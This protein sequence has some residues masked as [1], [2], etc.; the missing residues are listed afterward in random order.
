MAKFYIDSTALKKSPRQIGEINKEL[1]SIEKVL[2]DISL[3]NWPEAEMQSLADSVGEIAKDVKEEA[4]SAQDLSE[5][6][7]KIITTYENSEASLVAKKDTV[8]QN[9]VPG[10]SKEKGASNPLEALKNS[11]SP[12]AWDVL[13]FIA[14]LIPGLNILVDGY[15]LVDDINKFL[16][17]GKISAGEAGVLALDVISLG[18]DIAS[19]GS[20]CK[21]IKGAKTAEK[22]AQS[23][24]KETVRV[25]EKNAL[26]KEA[27]EQ[28]AKSAVEK[29]AEATAKAERAAKAAENVDKSTK[30]GRQ[31]AKDAQTAARNADKAVDAAKT[32]EK[33]AKEAADKSARAAAKKEAAEEAAE[34]AHKNVYR[35]VEEEMKKGTWDN[36]KDKADPENIMRDSA[37]NSIR[38]QSESDE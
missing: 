38:E 12:E 23:T 28:A 14:G 15:T 35:T 18:A 2:R 29:S 34:A 26:K 17:D 9:K 27:T 11:M 24:A 6:L 31:I 33:T 8:D 16:K 20:I 19:F 32:A 7:A 36:L 21:A 37:S 25:A 3:T 5:V 13:M 10:D 1:V 30:A 4:K 22:V